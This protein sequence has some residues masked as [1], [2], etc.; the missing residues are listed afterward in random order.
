MWSVTQ[1]VAHPLILLLVQGGQNKSKVCQYAS[2]KFFFQKCSQ[3]AFLPKSCGSSVLDKESMNLCVQL[4]CTE[5]YHLWVY[6][7][8][9]YPQYLQQTILYKV[10]FIAAL[11]FSLCF[12]VCMHACV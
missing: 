11:Y 10:I 6:S 8:E 5:L 2:I 7:Q 1:Y 4:P 9:T 3:A 12:H